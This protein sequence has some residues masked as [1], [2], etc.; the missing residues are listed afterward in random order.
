MLLF[1]DVETT[2]LPKRYN[3]PYHVID[4]WPRI[5]QIAWAGF[6]PDGTE[7]FADDAIIRPDDFVIPE[8]V[9]AIHGITQER[10]LREGISAVAA[11]EEFASDADRSSLLIA[12]NISFD[13]PIVAAALLRHQIPCD[14]VGKKGFCT[15]K[16][17]PIIK[18]CRIPKKNGGLKWPR[19]EELHR[20]LF[21]EDFDNA[22]D[23][24]A[25]VRATARCYFALKEIGVI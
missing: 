25:D 15:M 16:S 9:A 14:L 11:L 23:A 2:G 8:N 13:L 4:N 10:A 1:F 22:H 5:V 12:H 6:L 17:R 21:Q 7:C 20:T 24:R 19:L 3:V 18:F